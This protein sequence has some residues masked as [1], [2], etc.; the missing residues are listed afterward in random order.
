[1]SCETAGCKRPSGAV[2][3]HIADFVCFK[4][5]LVVECDGS[6]HGESLHDATRGEWLRRQGLAVARFWNHAILHER[7]NVLGAILAR[8]G[9][10]W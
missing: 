2:S 7:E 1:M 4:H 9:L 6:K 8:C 3:P 10:P 5:R